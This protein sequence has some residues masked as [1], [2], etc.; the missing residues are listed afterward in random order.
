MTKTIAIRKDKDEINVTDANG[1]V[2]LNI[3]VAS[4]SRLQRAD[5][6]LKTSQSQ[7]LIDRAAIPATPYT[8]P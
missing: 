6:S 7:L 8:V 4:S 1:Q 2:L 3:R 5:I